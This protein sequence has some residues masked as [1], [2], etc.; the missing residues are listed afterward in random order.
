MMAVPGLR[1]YEDI[2]CHHYYDHL[3]GEG[4]VVLG[5]KIDE[6]MCKRDDI[7]NELSIIVAGSH[8]LEAIPSKSWHG[9]RN[10]RKNADSI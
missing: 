7:Q 5:G 6:S 2:I 4:H 10:R 1:I 8:F 9:R 3:Q